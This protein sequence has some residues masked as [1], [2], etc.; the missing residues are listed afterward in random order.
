MTDLHLVFVAVALL[1]S[2]ASVARA[3]VVLIEAIAMG[4]RWRDRAEFTAHV[5]LCALIM[6]MA[7]EILS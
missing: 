2:G 5:G 7:T 1:I 6:V 4:W 3:F